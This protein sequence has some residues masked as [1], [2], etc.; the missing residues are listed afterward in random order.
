MLKG[1]ATIL[2]DPGRLEEC[3]NRNLVKFNK[4]K[5]KHHL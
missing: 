1:R 5:C 2:R 4:D 3:A